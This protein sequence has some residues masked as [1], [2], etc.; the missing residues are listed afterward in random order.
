MNTK[1]RKQRTYTNWEIIE[2]VSRIM[3]L[4]PHDLLVKRKHTSG[5]IFEAQKICMDIMYSREGLFQTEIKTIFN[6]TSHGS[7]SLAI[8]QHC[9]D[10]RTY[11]DYRA[12]VDRVH[13]NLDETI[14]MLRH[15]R[16]TA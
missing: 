10:Y 13:A 6:K 1:T 5:K 14:Q 12:Q 8:S 2:A 11:K 7:V 4:N 3:D 15:E 16:K 9:F